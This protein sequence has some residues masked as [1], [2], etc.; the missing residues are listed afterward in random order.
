MD[1]SLE[2][3]VWEREGKKPKATTVTLKASS[4][5]PSG[6][7]DANYMSSPLSPRERGRG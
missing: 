1:P 3:I 7:S 4:S 5:E 2:A 6:L